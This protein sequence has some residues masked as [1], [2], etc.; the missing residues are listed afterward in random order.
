MRTDTSSAGRITRKYLVISRQ[1]G[2][3][4]GVAVAYRLLGR[5]ADLQG[6]H[7][8]AINWFRRAEQ[9]L[10]S[11]VR[12]HPTKHLYANLAL[13]ADALSISEHT[14]GNAHAAVV[15][16]LR[17]IGY[18][19][20]MPNYDEQLL[21]YG[22]VSTL[23][24]GLG[25]EPKRLH[26]LQLSIELR[27]KPLHFP[28]KLLVPYTDMAWAMIEQ[29]RLPEAR[30][31]LNQ[32]KQLL[33]LPHADQYHTYYQRVLGIY[34]FE[35]GQYT[36]AQAAFRQ[37]LK[38][39]LDTPNVGQIID[40]E[41]SLARATWA[42]GQVADAR[43]QLTHSLRLCQRI[44]NQQR[45]AQILSVLA[46]LEEAQGPHRALV[47]LMYLKKWRTVQEQLDDEAT[48]QTILKLE[49]Q[50]RT[51]EQQ[52]Q[53]KVLHAQQQ[54]Q[55]EDLHRRTWLGYAAFG[56]A[57]LLTCALA[58]GYMTLRANKQLAIQQQQL[59]AQR[60]LKME[61][62]RQHV[63]TEAMLHGQDAE[64]NRIARD[65]HDGLGGM[66]STV[67]HHLG[68]MGNACELPEPGTKLLTRSL[69]YLDESISELR[70][71]A[72]DMMPETLHRFGL[73]PA[74]QDLC[75]KFNGH[76][77]FQVQFQV[78]DLGERLPQRVE[79]VV[80]RL[81][82]EL[83]NNVLKHAHATRAI[84][85]LTRHDSLVQLIVE[86]DGQGFMPNSPHSGLGL[87]NIQARVDY[88]CGVLDWHSQPGQGT[89]ATVEFPITD[90]YNHSQLTYSRSA[91]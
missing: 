6:Q 5:L 59:H 90:V 87:R 64:R 73:V 10:K 68:A 20:V 23:F 2:Y 16:G 28:E 83:L 12:A 29:Q 41:Y 53:I 69:L 35:S 36:Q 3:D 38:A 46:E 75:D 78:Y 27:E 14:E 1:S 9:L 42:L 51:R 21:I 40:L 72:Q 4:E 79:L 81:V 58:L 17:A 49:T 66:L 45:E 57:G 8:V 86:D 85:Q 82:Q 30:S 44:G 88:L 26:Y 70:R 11:L 22:N 43:R 19:K 33:T 50:F 15:A 25:D 60:L 84:V 13:T 91:R 24:Q 71:V 52:Q 7:V 67:K 77:H 34:H 80:Y 76:Q 56:L 65:L 39:T 48:K 55:K 61:H 62:E 47:A 31:Y 89:T 63:A 18:A 54:L 74:I 32:A 37:A